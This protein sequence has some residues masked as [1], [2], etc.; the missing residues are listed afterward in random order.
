M[1]IIADMH[2]HTVASTHAYST[3]TEMAKAAFDMG[4]KF[5]A[6]TDHTPNSTDGPHVWHF[7]NLHKAI[8]RVLCGVNIIYGAEASVADYSGKLDFDDS[9]CK[10]LDWIV[11][12]VHTD[13][14]KSGGIINNTE[15]YLGMAENPYIDVIG[16]PVAK[17]FEFDVETAIKKLVEYDKLIEI[18]ENTLLWKNSEGTYRNL[19]P[20]SKKYDAKFID[21][22]D[23]HF[24]GAVGKVDMGIKLLEEFE[25][26]KELIVNIDYDRMYNCIEDAKRKKAL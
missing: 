19:I 22:R 24:W 3:I 1:R 26:P 5:L 9:E 12:S 18:N 11:G 17:G 13:I 14:L 7:H 8:P 6:C 15:C 20:I 23:A 16:H 25:Y 4:L 10:R 21:Y 2:T